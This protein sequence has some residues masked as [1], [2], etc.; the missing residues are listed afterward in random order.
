MTKQEFYRSFESILEMPS[1]S[2][3]GSELLDGMSAWD[4][5][6]ALSFIAFADSELKVRVP[7]ERLTE[8]KTVFDLVDLFPRDVLK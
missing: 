5:L 7:I 1:G 4:S 6:A 3:S 8:C 2:I